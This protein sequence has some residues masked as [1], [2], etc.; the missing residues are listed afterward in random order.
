MQT[1]FF[2]D[3]LH[4]VKEFEHSHACKS[5]ATVDD[6]RV[7]MNDKKYAE[8]SPTKL[9]KN[10]KHQVSFTENEICKQVLLLSRYSK[11]L[12]RKGLGEFPELA[13]EEF[14][15]LYRLKDE[16][17]L[18]K[19]QLIERNAHEKQTGTQIIKRLLEAGFLEEKNDEDDKRSKRVNLTK[20]GEEIF[21]ASV[22]RVNLT[23]KILS[24]KLDHA[25]KSEFLKTLKKLNEF[26]THIYADYRHSEMKT[27]SNFI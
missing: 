7:W 25:E 9:F 6:F 12:I 23:S 20:K 13:N 14:T 18:T 8:E 24:G 22:S 5:N 3:L 27:I 4:Q 1:D 19:I 2:I 21:H 10:E 17:H 11:L 26:H 16:P 15:Y